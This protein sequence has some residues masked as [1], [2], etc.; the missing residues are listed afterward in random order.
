MDSLRVL[1]ELPT[2]RGVVAAGSPTSEPSADTT[3]SVPETVDLNE[4]HAVTTVR[5]GTLCSGGVI[6]E[7]TVTQSSNRFGCGST[8][9][10]LTCGC[11]RRLL[12]YRE[13]WTAFA[14]AQ[15]LAA[16]A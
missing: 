13:V 12:A 3:N 14:P 6:H 9:G 10:N 16:D 2:E 1:T 8:G 5:T 7:V 15:D 11:G 4:C